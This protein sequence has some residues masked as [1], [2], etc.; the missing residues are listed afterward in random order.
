MTREEFAKAYETQQKIALQNMLKAIDESQKN[1]TTKNYNV[2][3][4]DVIVSVFTESNNALINTL[5][6]TGVIKF[7]D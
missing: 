2:L 1:N 5:I 3:L 6:D 4:S 7:D